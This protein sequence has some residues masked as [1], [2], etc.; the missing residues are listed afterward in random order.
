M[1]WNQMY[2]LA[3]VGTEHEYYFSSSDCQSISHCQRVME[4][5]GFGYLEVKADGTRGVDVEIV[6]PPLPLVPEVRAEYSRFMELCVSLG[7]KY[8]ERCG[9]HVHIGKRRLKPATD[10]AAYIAHAKERFSNRARLPD[11]SWFCDDGMHFE[12]IKDVFRRYSIAQDD[13]NAI[14][15]RDRRASRGMVKEIS[16]FTATP[17]ARQRL[18][19]CTNLRELQSLV[20]DEGGTLKYWAVNL[21][22]EGTIEFR[23][24]PASTSRS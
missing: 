3:T 8:R 2:T 23:Q 1:T 22:I 6:F 16:R 5:N 17:E 19:N 7:L 10:I 11:D 13:I 15:P 21:G 24:H 14:L 18:D 12:L 9:L 20:S 4:Q